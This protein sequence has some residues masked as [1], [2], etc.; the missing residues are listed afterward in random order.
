MSP[1]RG[2]PPPGPDPRVALAPLERALVAYHEGRP[3]TLRVHM[4]DGGYE[5]LP[6]GF[7]FRSGKDLRAADQAVLELARGRVLDVGAGAGAVAVAL[8]ASGHE[9]TALE[10]L[11]GL[12]G[13]LAERGLG[14]PRRG[15][16]WTFRSRRRYDTVLAL[17][18]GT[19]AAGSLGG[20]EPLLCALAAPLAPGG[21][22]LIDSTDLRRKGRRASRP[23]GRYVGELQY[24]LEYDGERGPPFPQLFVDRARLGSAARAV[25]LTATT[26]WRGEGGEY[27][28]R[29][30]RR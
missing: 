29:L 4:D 2:G 15:D 7:F 25:G 10:V 22:I 1:A 9:V 6:A 23:D 24:Q 16:L 18:N 11:P 20:L 3:A 30:V 12:V 5:D 21:Q 27:L 28:A 8:E 13:V 19:A 26:V 17:M 14:D